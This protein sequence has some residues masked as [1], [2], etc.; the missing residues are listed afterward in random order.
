MTDRQF[1]EAQEELVEDIYEEYGLAVEVHLLGEEKELRRRWLNCP[2]PV[3][4]IDF[5]G[6][7]KI[8]AADVAK[9]SIWLDMTASEVKRHRLEDRNTQ[10]AYFSLKKEWKQ[11][12]KA[13]NY[14]D[15]I[16]KNRYNT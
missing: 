12:Q 3:V 11:P 13:R 7:E 8:S 16:S 2:F 1:Q 9:N 10:I 14:L 6:E 5:S 15:T 4:I